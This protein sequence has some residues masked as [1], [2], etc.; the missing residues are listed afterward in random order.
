VAVPQ[1]SVAAHTTAAAHTRS[2]GPVKN[3]HV[4]NNPVKKKEEDSDD[5][6]SANDDDDDDDDDDEK[7]EEEYED[8]RRIM[9]V[10]ASCCVIDSDK[11]MP[12]STAIALLL[13][14]LVDAKSLRS[15]PDTKCTDAY[16][17]NPTKDACLSTK[18]HYLRPCAFCTEIGDSHCYNLDE[19][20]WAKFFG[21]TCEAGSA[22]V[23]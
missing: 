21:A 5:D 1:K 17:K 23:A 11:G 19:A 10:P 3:N 14:S 16:R 4:K 8:G 6:D 20:R 9:R 22:L 18:D 13:S 12:P 15:D 7:Q 2:K